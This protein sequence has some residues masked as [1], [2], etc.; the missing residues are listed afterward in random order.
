MTERAPIILP[1]ALASLIAEPRWVVWKWITGKNGKPTKPPFQGRAPSRHASSTDPATW[2]DLDTAMRAYCSGKCDGI[3]FALNASGVGAFDVD[4]CRDATTGAIHPWAQELVRRCGSYAE[5]TPSGTGIRIIGTASGPALHRKFAVP[6]A[7]GM[8]IEV[9]RSADRYITVSGV[10]IGEVQQLADIDAQADAVASRLDGARQTDAG[11]ATKSGRHDLNSLIRDGCGNDFGGDRSRAVWYVINQLLKQGR[12]VDEIVGVLLDRGNGIS[13]HVYDQRHPEAYARRQAEKAQKEGG[14]GADVDAEIKR[15]AKLSTVDYERERK[16]ASEQ[17]G[18]RAAI[19]DRLVQAARPDDDDGKQGRA[20]SFPE[21]ELWPEPVDGAALL[22]SVAEAIRKYVVLADH[23]R[24]AAALWVLHSYLIDRFLVS[25]RLAISSPAKQCGKT[26][27]LD[28]LAR[29]A[30]R[31][32]PTANVTP[33]AVFRVVE[34]YRP[35]LLVDEADTFLRDNDELRGVIDSGHRRGGAV[36]RTVGD[37]HEPR[38]FSTYSACA[39]ALIGKLPD[40]LYDRAVVIDL[41]RRLPEEKIAPFRPDRAGDLD[42]LARQLARWARDHADRIA[43]VDPEMPA[44]VFNRE[45]DNWRP[46][47]AIAQ[48]AGGDWP[49]RARKAV[50]QSHQARD[51]ESRLQLLLTDIRAIF[52]ERGADRLASSD[53]V[54]ELAA[55]EGRVWA[56]YKSGKPISQN[57]LARALKPLGIAPEVARVG[58]KLAR[59]YCLE[60][61]GEAFERYLTQEGDSDRNTVTKLDKTGTSGAFQTVTPNPMLRLKNPRSSNTDGLCYGLYG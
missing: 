6:K 3:G 48:V 54:D 1:P 23:S 34:A 31:P 59:G 56:E 51:G 35:A 19:L 26:T 40:T 38:A 45:A 37:D 24:D 36:L 44:G 4:H 12:S 42:V 55:I 61:F 29:M 28:V 32:L 21:P 11:S 30:L 5:V 25:P 9:Y 60:Q 10:Q 52:A 22:D 47:V 27:L 33:S 20:I 39:I 58:S 14:E 15:L 18:I 41:K 57:Q 46:L 50:E 7:D 8:S 13:A 49:K 53:L 43:E 16:S 17:L 2:C